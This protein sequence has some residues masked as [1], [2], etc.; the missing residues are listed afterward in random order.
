VD[1][2]AL[3][4]DERLGLG[5]G[6]GWEK[7]LECG[8]GGGGGVGDEK[9]GVIGEGDGKLRPLY[10]VRR[11]ESEGERVSAGGVDHAMDGEGARV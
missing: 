6:L 2:L 1:G 3:G 4:V 11:G 9:G 10:G 8:G 7:P 5:E